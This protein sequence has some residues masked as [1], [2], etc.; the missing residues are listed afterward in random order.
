MGNSRIEDKWYNTPTWWMA[1]L[2]FVGMMVGAMTWVYALSSNIQSVTEK[3]EKTVKIVEK[4]DDS[5]NSLKTDSAVIREKLS[6]IER[7]VLKIE[8]KL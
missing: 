2:A 8:K 5:I 4:H 3:L 6:T 7:V 1:I